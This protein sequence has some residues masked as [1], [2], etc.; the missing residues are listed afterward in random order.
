M[1]RSLDDLR[2]E[3]R[4]K[5]E[6]LI[7]ECA[8]KG[9]GLIITSTL[10]TPKE[11][12]AYYSQGRKDLKFVNMARAEAGLAPITRLENRRIITH[13]LTSTHESGCAFDVAIR[14]HGAIVWEIKADLNENHI[15]DYEEI[16]ATGEAIGLRWGGRFKF[17]DYV[18]FE[19]TGGLTFAELKDGKRPHEHISEDSA[20]A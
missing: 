2:P 9:V 6:K 5:A 16:G 18:H 19:Y 10:R 11:Q 3:V 20:L 1:S 17:R 4:E 7:A 15:P 12:F 14:R 8:G 13:N